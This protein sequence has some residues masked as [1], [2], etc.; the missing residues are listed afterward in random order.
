MEFTHSYH[1]GGQIVRQSN[2]GSSARPAGIGVS[3]IRA[4]VSEEVAAGNVAEMAAESSTDAIPTSTDTSHMDFGAPR[5]ERERLLWGALSRS[6]T[7]IQQL[8][9][10]IRSLLDINIR[11][12]EQL[13]ST[14]ISERPRKRAKTTHHHGSDQNRYNTIGPPLFRDQNRQIE[15]AQ[16][17]EEAVGTTQRQSLV[18]PIAQSIQSS[19]QAANDNGSSQGN[20]NALHIFASS[21]LMYQPATATTTTAIISK[22]TAGPGAIARAL[23]SVAGAFGTHECASVVIPRSSGVSMLDIASPSNQ[24]HGD[25]QA[26]QMSASQQSNDMSLLLTAK[27]LITPVSATSPQTDGRDLHQKLAAPKAGTDVGGSSSSPGRTKREQKA[28]STD[29]GEITV[30]DPEEIPSIGKFESAR[31]L[32]AF[33]ERVREFEQTHGSQWREKMD[34]R[35][36]QNWSRISAVYNRAVQLRGPGTAAAD[37]ERAF[38]QIE[39]EMAESK[40]T[41][42]RYSQLVRKRL[43]AERRQSTA[44]PQHQHQQHQKR[45]IHCKGVDVDSSGSIGGERERS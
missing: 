26:Q 1:L 4:Q 30:G 17:Q 10:Q 6:Q 24:A 29:T 28:R 12:A 35:R 13:Q 5:T 15:S 40:V 42:T 11:Y 31:A 18:L 45:Q 43:N 23:P 20:S 21:E 27:P 32:Y 8:Q 33:K 3:D 16:A 14:I 34:S 39:S 9:S 44:P 38:K 19:G 41:L 22:T 36:R 37:V 2:T 25:Q 7:E